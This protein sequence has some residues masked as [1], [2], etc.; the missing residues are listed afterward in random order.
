MNRAMELILQPD[1]P[2][3]AGKV[4]KTFD[5][6][7]DRAEWLQQFAAAKGI[8]QVDVIQAAIDHMRQ[9]ERE[10]AEAA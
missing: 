1:R 7:Q 3:A 8:Q 4:R 6:T 2:K 10:Y 5:L 9:L